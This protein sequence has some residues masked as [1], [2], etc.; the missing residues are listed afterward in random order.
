MVRNISGDLMVI[1]AQAEELNEIIQENNPTIF[2]LLSVKGK[3]IYFPRKGILSQTAE[4]R[5]SKINATIGVA[6]EDDGTPMRIPSIAEKILLDPKDVFLYA[7]SYGKGELREVWKRE[8][9]KKNPSL[10]GTMSLP[11]VTNGITNGLNYV[12]YLFV[13]PG[14]KLIL[15]DKFWGNYRLIFEKSFDAKLE[16][17]NLFTGDRFNI[18][19]FAEKV[20]EGLDKKIVLLNFPN[21]PTGYTPTNEEAH[22]IVNVIKDRATDGNELCVIIDDA[23]FGLV[24][25]DDIFQESLFSLLAD[26]DENVL[27]IKVDGATKEHY[28]WGLR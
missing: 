13:N 16:T 20:F 19:N 3:E 2:D 28:A 17:F 27:A 11:V 6:S 25:E 10:K 12:G 21:N 24:Y 9:Q 15:P 5:V 14:D 4:A 23:Y 26:L 1:S 8:I 22:Q 18:D 7:P